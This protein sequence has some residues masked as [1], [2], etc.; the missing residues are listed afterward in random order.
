MDK[1]GLTL[2]YK[3]EIKL[4]IEQ[5]VTNAERDKSVCRWKKLGNEE[6]IGYFVAYICLVP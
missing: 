2:I 4:I 5:H 1:R 3:N 6:D